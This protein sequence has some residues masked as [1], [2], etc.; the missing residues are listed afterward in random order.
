MD[1]PC[2]LDFMLL[3]RYGEYGPVSYYLLPGTSHSSTYCI[4]GEYTVEAEALTGTHSG[5][6]VEY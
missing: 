1:L 5:F 6:T 3:S 4:K 2:L